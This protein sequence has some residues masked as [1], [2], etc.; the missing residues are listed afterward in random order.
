MSRDKI[1]DSTPLT[2][3]K[4][5]SYGS[6]TSVGLFPAPKP[7]VDTAVKASAAPASNLLGTFLSGCRAVKEG[8][9]A[10]ME[11]RSKTSGHANR[12]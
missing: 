10:A 1:N 7:P 3:G 2:R 9:E 6:A 8:I 5:T 12:F 11:Q 4:G